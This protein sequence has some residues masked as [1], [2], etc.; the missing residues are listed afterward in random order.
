M[1]IVTVLTAMSWGQRVS[2]HFTAVSV[3]VL[4]ILKGVGNVCLWFTVNQSSAGETDDTVFWM[5]P[6]ARIT[7]M[8]VSLA[9]TSKHHMGS[10][11]ANKATIP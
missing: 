8:S 3:R 7:T 4:A 2:L 5:L 11:L 1:G 6:C 10:N 9:R